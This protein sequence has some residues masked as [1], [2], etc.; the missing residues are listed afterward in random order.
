MFKINL[1]QMD[2]IASLKNAITCTIC[3][4]VYQDPVTFGT[5]RHSFCKQCA[6]GLVEFRDSC[7][8]CAVRFNKSNITS[9][10][11]LNRIISATQSLV[12][13]ALLLNDPKYHSSLATSSSSSTK[14]TT[15]LVQFH[16]GDLVE[17]QARTWAGINKPGG[18]A[19]ILS[20][21]VDEGSYEVK[22]V[23]TGAKEKGILPLY[24]SQLNLESLP[25]NRRRT[26]GKYV[27]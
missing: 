16:E 12:H 20:F 1:H 15:S 19:R 2:L 13:E 7:P 23:L 11:A 26:R 8:L 17:V 10:H 4:D 3:L 9:L 6:L 18:T 22:Y 14:P 24:I 5:C 25:T 21:S 27:Y